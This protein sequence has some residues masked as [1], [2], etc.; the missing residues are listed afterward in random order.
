MWGARGPHDTFPRP[1][2][3]VLNEVPGHMLHVGALALSL[4][5]GM[6]VAAQQAA[7]L[8]GRAWGNSRSDP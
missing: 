3:E 4:A 5:R 7:Q 6:L 8:H 1:S 2:A